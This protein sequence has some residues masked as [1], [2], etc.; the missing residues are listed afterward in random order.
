MDFLQIYNHSNGLLNLY[1]YVYKS[2]SKT[3]IRNLQYH[4]DTSRDVLIFYLF[5][6]W[7]FQGDVFECFRALGHDCVIIWQPGDTHF[8]LGQL[9]I[10]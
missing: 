8:A 1:I 2:H 5:R 9:T 6:G 4:L 7:D 10:L 3:T